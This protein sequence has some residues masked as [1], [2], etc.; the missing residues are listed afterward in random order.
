MDGEPVADPAALEDEL[1]TTLLDDP[2]LPLAIERT[3]HPRPAILPPPRRGH[4]RWHALQARVRGARTDVSGVEAA[5]QDGDLIGGT[6]GIAGAESVPTIVG[7]PYGGWRLLASLEIRSTARPGYNSEEE[8]I[9]KRYTVVELRVD[10]DRRALDVPPTS[11]ADLRSWTSAAMSEVA[12]NAS[13]GTQPIVGC[14]SSVSI[15][16]DGH[17]GLGVP[18]SLLTPTTWLFA[19]LGLKPGAHFALRT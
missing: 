7:G 12:L 13:I 15:A 8:D 10:G 1:A 4:D 19:A 2:D 14:D 9:A 17:F 16:G 11:S 5:R 18:R 3:R 6:V